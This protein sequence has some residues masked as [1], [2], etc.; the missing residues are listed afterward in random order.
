MV[1]CASQLGEHLTLIFKATP[2]CFLLGHSPTDPQNA[3]GRE[4]PGS[5]AISARESP[6]TDKRLRR[7][8]AHTRCSK[9]SYVFFRGETKSNLAL[10]C[11]PPRKTVCAVM[12]QPSTPWTSP[13][14]AL[15]DPLTAHQKTPLERGTPPGKCNVFRR[16]L[17]HIWAKFDH[18]RLSRAVVRR[19]GCVV[20]PDCDELAMKISGNLALKR[21][22]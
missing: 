21:P 2:P 14:S 18:L 10:C 13:E 15:S 3:A 19:S 4:H 16:E 7:V 17:R 1:S 11:L 12:E 20:P 9:I 6:A 22:P 5:P 8:A